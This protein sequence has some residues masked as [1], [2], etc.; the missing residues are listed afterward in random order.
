M[1]TEIRMQLGNVAINSI[2]DKP[3]NRTG[4]NQNFIVLNLNKDTSCQ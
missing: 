1:R 4:V 3:I 2:T